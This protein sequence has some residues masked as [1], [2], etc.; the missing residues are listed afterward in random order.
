[1]IPNGA[2]GVLSTD[3]D[4]PTM[5]I[6]NITNVNS[7]I[8]TTLNDGAAVIRQDVS[9]TIN[10]PSYLGAIVSADGAIVYWVNDRRPLPN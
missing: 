1:M 6:G 9:H 3:N 4:N 5:N 7:G 8:Y 2:V 10:Q